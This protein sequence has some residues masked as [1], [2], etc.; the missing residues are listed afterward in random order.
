MRSGK[1]FSGLAALIML[2]IRYPTSRWVVVRKDLQ[3]IKRNTLPSWEKIKPRNFIVSHN[4]DTQT[5][6]FE[7]GSQIIFFGENYDKDKDLNRWRGLECNG[8]LL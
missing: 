6:T 7:N 3:T 5:V 8:W 4:M 2:S 1:T